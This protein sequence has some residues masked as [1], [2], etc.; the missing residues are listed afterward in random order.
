MIFTQSWIG[1]ISS[2]RFGGLTRFICPCDLMI[3]LI[4]AIQTTCA[5]F[6][7]DA[8]S[9]VSGFLHRNLRIDP[10]D[11]KSLPGCTS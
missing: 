2:L 10:T 3:S 4:Q 8:I 6:L 1:I 9:L 7:I 11:E 5:L